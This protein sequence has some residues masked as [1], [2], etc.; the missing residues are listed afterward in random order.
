MNIEIFVW[1][2]VRVLVV[3]SSYMCADAVIVFVQPSGF[4]VRDA[5][6]LS[7]V[8]VNCVDDF[9]VWDLFLKL[10][11]WVECKT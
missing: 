7:F 9:C 11:V 4:V 8:V 2:D 1:F 6:V 10:V 5:D 3:F